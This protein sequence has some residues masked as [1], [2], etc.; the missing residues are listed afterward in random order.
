MN[1]ETARGSRDLAGRHANTNNRDAYTLTEL[2]AVIGIIGILLGITLPA[3]Q[4]VRQTARRTTCS[5]N[6]RQVM[7]AALAHEANGTGFPK[8]D[9]GR[10]GSLMIALLPHLE[11]PMI[12]SRSKMPLDTAIGETY[13]DRLVEMANEEIELLICPASNIEDNQ[14]S[15]A[16]QGKFATH[17]YGVAGPV[18]NASSTDGTRAYSFQQ[19]MPSPASGPIGLHGL[20]SPRRNGQ[21]GTRRL[22]DITDGTSNT[23]AFGEISGYDKDSP[24]ADPLRSGWTFGAGYNSSGVVV[25]LYGIKSVA[26]QINE[27]PTDLNTVP[28][29]S[30]HPGG[31]H[32]A[33]ADGSIHFVDD[34]VSVDI[35]KIFASIDQS[36]QMETIV[37]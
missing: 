5:S 29:S 2:L 21:F 27:L 35:L 18:G 26:H 33:Y 16:M 11:E 19:L 10:G 30:N 4:M 34:E 31:T 17:Y 7:V 13:Q 8:A 6:L 37:Q 15:I 22:K 24:L 36:E 23:L 14:T 32:F 3:M 25:D 1:I 20:F 28:F 12:A 9:N